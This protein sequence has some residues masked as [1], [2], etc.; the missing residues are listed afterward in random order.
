LLVIITV[1]IALM[2][3]GFI[4]EMSV[5]SS[6]ILLPLA[7]VTIAAWI[8]SKVRNKEMKLTAITSLA[9]GTIVSLYVAIIYGPKKAFIMTWYGLPI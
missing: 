6:V 7:P 8:T 3:P 5:L 1:C 2:K 9:L 4:V